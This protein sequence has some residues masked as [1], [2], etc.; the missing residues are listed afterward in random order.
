MSLTDR[1]KAVVVSL[2][3]QGRVEEALKLVCSAYEKVPPRVKVGRVKGHD[4]ALAV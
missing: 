1:E 3:L 2:I 4:K